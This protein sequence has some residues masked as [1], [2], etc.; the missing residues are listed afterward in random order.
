VLWNR[1][2]LSLSPIIYH[3]HY[4]PTSQVLFMVQQL[5][6]YKVMWNNV[7]STVTTARPEWNRESP[8]NCVI[9]HEW[10]LQVKN[11]HGEFRNRVLPSSWVSQKMTTT[12][13]STEINYL[14]AHLQEKRFTFRSTMIM[15]A[16]SINRESSVNWIVTSERLWVKNKHGLTITGC[17][18]Y[19][20]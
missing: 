15:A 6:Q 3:H 8:L 1:Y 16:P 7:R 10:R 14:D 17:C 20:E 4:L 19:P 2:V 9:R 5:T 13:T 11:N 18:F 12:N